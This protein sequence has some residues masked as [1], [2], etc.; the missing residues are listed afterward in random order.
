VA[1]PKDRPFTIAAAQLSPVFLDRQATVEKACEVIGEAGRSGAKIVVFPEAFV[2]GYPDWVWVLR[3]SQER[4]HRELYAELLDQSVTIPS[5]AVDKLCRAA[6]AAGTYVVVGVSERNADA[7]GG[8]I[9]N[10]LLFIDDKGQLMGLHRKLVPTSAERLVWTPGDGSTLHVFDTA[11]GRIGGLIC[12]ENYMPLARY[13]MYAWGTQIYVAPTWD[14]GDGWIATLQH[15]A[16]EGR[17][18]VVGCCIA[19][20]TDQI[21]DGYAFK[22]E[23]PEGHEWINRGASAIVGPDGHFLAEPV[24]REEKIIYAEVDPAD[25][26]GSHYWLDTA[27]HYAR[28]D[29]FQLTVNREPNPMIATNGTG[30]ATDGHQEATTARPRRRTGR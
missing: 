23:Y 14:G 13:A 12:W 4:E 29:V 15:I 25:L 24:L 17:C 28:P 7:S 19:M 16:R 30:T 2:P 3:P 11:Y 27:G 9:Y 26:R 22:K 8:S 6:K 5:P 20:R 10:T 18:V 21:P 1:R